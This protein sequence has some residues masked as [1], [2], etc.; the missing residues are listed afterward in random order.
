M[1]KTLNLLLLIIFTASLASCSKNK[2][3]IKAINNYNIIDSVSSDFKSNIINLDSTSIISMI[4]SDSSF[5]LFMYSDFCSSCKDVKDNLNEYFKNNKYTIYGF[6]GDN[7]SEYVL[8]HDSLPEVFPE[9]L[10]TPELKVIKDGKHVDSIQTSKLVNNRLIKSAINSFLYT[11]NIYTVT[12]EY[13]YKAFKNSFSEYEEIRYSS[14]SKEKMKPL[15]DIY[16]SDSNKTYLVIDEYNF[17]HI[18]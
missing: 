2:N 9:R 6:N 1:K 18:E 3:A 7:P 17:S 5:L 16:N 15:L 8:L 14:E 12:N 4:N 10:S 11:S 13:T